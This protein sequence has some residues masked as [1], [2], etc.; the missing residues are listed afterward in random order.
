[1]FAVTSSIPL[2]SILLIVALSVMGAGAD[3]C[4][5]LAGQGS[6]PMEPGWFWLGFVLYMLTVPGWFLVMR[7]TALS[8][9]GVVYAVST[10]L[11]LVGADLV[12]FREKL[13]STEMIAV[14]LAVISI[15]LLRRFT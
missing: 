15:V 7:Q 6:K 4:I 8:S 3:I 11:L 2:N 1:V 10:V 5:K 9:V 13:A 14:T 12:F